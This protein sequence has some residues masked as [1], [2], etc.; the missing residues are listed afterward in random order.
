MDFLKATSSCMATFDFSHKEP[1]L[2]NDK[3]VREKVEL[4]D[5]KRNALREATQYFYISIY[6]LRENFA[7]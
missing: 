2:H 7:T 1:W 3:K 5:F 6:I 4:C